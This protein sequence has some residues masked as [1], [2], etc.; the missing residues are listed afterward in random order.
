MPKIAVGMIIFNG[1][2][3]L[4]EC[5]ESIYPHV[6][7]ILISE[8]PV[9]Y[10]QERGYGKSDD[11]TI[12]TIKEFPDPD[13]KIIL[14]QGQ[15]SE[16]DE[17]CSAYIPY[18]R[19]DMEYL[20]NLDCDEI[21]KSED[22]IKLKALLDEHQFTSVGFKSTSFFGGFDHYLTGFEQGVEFLR[23]HRIYPGSYW[24]THRPPSITHTTPNPL[25]HKHLDGHI[26]SDQL[27][28][29]MYHYSYVFP[30]Q[31]EQ[32]VRYYSESLN[33]E[34]CIFDYFNNVY[35][36]WVCGDHI[37]KGHVEERYEGVH[38]WIPGKRGPCYTTPFKGGH[39]LAIE[40]NLDNLQRKFNEQLEKF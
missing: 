13:N 16:K 7:Q 17:Q 24:R 33:K 28:I 32:K 35:L 39:P 36:P 34:G 6:D 31:V 10:W 25:P 4:K 38:E 27:G 2:Y 21:F 19:D 1:N 9:K 15:Y 8:G 37:T 11:G 29:D 22:I 23:M 20:W 14:H 40:I 30:D 18:L 5:L 3:V 12:E 26:L